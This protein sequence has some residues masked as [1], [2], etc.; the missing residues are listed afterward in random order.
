LQNSSFK[1]SAK[2][3]DFCRTLLQA[4]WSKSK[5][6][7]LAAA[8]AV[9]A[10]C[11]VWIYISCSLF[12]TLWTRLRDDEEA[13]GKFAVQLYF[14]SHFLCIWDVVFK[15]C[16]PNLTLCSVVVGNWCLLLCCSRDTMW[17]ETA[18]VAGLL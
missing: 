13:L 2:I 1:Q 14:Y 6:L 11:K 8:P 12:S 7:L 16:V 9:A 18:A 17:L 4:F 3:K 15:L 10:A 5:R